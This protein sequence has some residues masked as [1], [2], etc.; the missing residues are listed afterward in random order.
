MLGLFGASTLAFGVTAAQASVTI[1]SPSQ[2]NTQSSTT[3]QAAAQ[4]VGGG[5][6][7]GDVTQKGTNKSTTDLSNTQKVAGGEGSLV[8]G[9]PSQSNSQTAGT[10]QTLD[11]QTP[12]VTS[13]GGVHIGDTT[14]TGSNKSNTEASN[15]QS[16]AGGGDA[17]IIGSPTQSN[18]QNLTTGQL[19]AQNAGGTGSVIIGDV[20]QTASNKS[21][22]E[23]ENTQSV[24]G[25]DGAIVDGSPAQSSNQ[26][27]GTS[28]V[29]GQGASGAVI[30]GGDE[31]I[32]QT[33][34]NKSNTEVSSGAHS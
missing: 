27:V 11:Q 2:T 29:I 12:P 28:Q 31:G 34:S 4:N 17:I 23:A 16:V 6:I 13:P 3:G 26:P 24:G 25:G 14:Q 8:L 21:N 9:S 5:L 1:G 30:L 10:S 15:T 32:S 20:S 33:Q 7:V 22:T 18:T 19:I